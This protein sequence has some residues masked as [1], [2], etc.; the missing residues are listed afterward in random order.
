MHA[1]VAKAY[2]PDDI[3]I[4]TLMGALGQLDAG[5]TTLFD[6]SHNNP[7]PDH[8]DRALDALFESG[9]RAVFGFGTA[10]PVLDNRDMPV[11]E[12]LHPEEEV[13]RLRRGRLADDIARVRL[14]LAIRGP[15][16]SSIE[17]TTHDI[18]LGEKYGVMVSAHLGGRMPASR[19]TK[20]GVRALAKAG[21]ISPAFNAVH[22]NKLTDDELRI[23][24]DAGASFTATPEVEMQM[25]HGFPVVGRVIALGG[26]PSIGTDVDAAVGPDLLRQVRF[27]LQLQRGLDNARV[28]A[29]GNDISMTSLSAKD[30]LGWAT[31]GGAKALGLERE[32][33]T[34]TVGKYAD[35]IAIRRE[36]FTI[37]PAEDAAAIA[38]FLA[39]P[40]SIDTV[41]VAG[42]TMKRSGRL[43]FADFERRLTELQRSRQ[44]V[45]HG[46]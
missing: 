28:H 25:G 42:K 24:A 9:I 41:L 20:D 11:G 22:C 35:L 32:I 33:G 17:A 45:L 5:V 8:T 26:V 30:A 12:L 40:S 1:G 38:L 34:L 18:R 6:W 39:T 15:D 31:T 44:R 23:L 37:S 29:E 7:T 46:L 43:I 4:G 19:K 2:T 3:H 36:D 14:A 21:L 13:R 16:Q 27:A 10:K